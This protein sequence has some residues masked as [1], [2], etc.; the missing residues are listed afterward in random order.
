M[1]TYRNCEA[2]LF[3]QIVDYV[4]NQPKYENIFSDIV[5]KQ[6]KV[7]KYY[8]KEECKHRSKTP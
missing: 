5:S 7:N 6:V 4:T 8:W 1:W 3:M 2:Y